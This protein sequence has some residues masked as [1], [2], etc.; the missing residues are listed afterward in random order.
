MRTRITVEGCGR[1]VGVQNEY[2]SAR[3]LRSG[4]P[5]ERILAMR[6]HALGDVSITL[7]AC[8]ALRRTYP[9]ARF[10]FLTASD[11]GS[12]PRSAGIFDN[13]ETIR[14][15]SS[16]TFRLREAF[17]TGLALRGNG[18]DLVLDLQRN[19]M[20]RIV[21]LLISP[22]A[23]AEFD[24]FSPIPAG[25]RTLQVFQKAGITGLEAR[26]DLHPSEAAL[27]QATDLLRAH[28]WDGVKPIVLLNPGGLWETRNWPL[29][30]YAALCGLWLKR[31]PVQFLLLGTSRIAEKASFLK[32]SFPESVVDLVGLTTPGTAL[33]VIQ[34]VSVAVSEDSGLLHLAWVSG[35]PTL[36]LFG[37]S[38]SDWSRPLGNHTA[39]LHSG[40][41]PCGAC[42]SSIC[43]YGDVHCLTRYSPEQVLET[44]LALAAARGSG[45]KQ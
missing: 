24:R 45:G 39:L 21:R 20:S 9:Q 44:A 7:P 8:A 41:L 19:W 30:S 13:V 29:S 32:R 35:I 40:D 43:R 22:K 23:W 14:I 11:W 42:M 34:H 3:A 12:L 15:L 18:Y 2:I 17:R 27:R 10:D 28:G 5:P 6:F 1:V 37:S 25:E 38:R 31:E 36:A 16:R 26:C 4:E 33:A